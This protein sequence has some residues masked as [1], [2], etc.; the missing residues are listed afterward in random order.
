MLS[1]NSH[2]SVKKE[3]M[4]IKVSTFEMCKVVLN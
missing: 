4:V 1:H 2:F 3:E